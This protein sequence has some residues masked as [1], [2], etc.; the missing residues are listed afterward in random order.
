MNRQLE[1]RLLEIE[2]TCQEIRRDAEGVAP[3]MVRLLLGLACIGEECT[4]V[5]SDGSR[6][7]V[8]IAAA[9]AAKAGKFTQFTIHTISD[10]YILDKGDR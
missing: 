9:T 1:A 5:A 2:N 3:K 6:V 4:L 8:R 10:P 7:K